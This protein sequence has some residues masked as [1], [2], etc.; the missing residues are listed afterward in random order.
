MALAVGI[1]AWVWIPALEFIVSNKLMNIG[2]FNVA[3]IH[4]IDIL[5]RLF[6]GEIDGMSGGFPNI[7]CGIPALLLLPYFFICKRINTKEKIIYSLL[8][9][10]LVISCVFRPLYI[11]WHGFEVPNGWNYRFAYIISFVICVIAA[12]TVDRF[13]LGPGLKK[14]IPIGAILLLMAVL[15]RDTSRIIVNTIIV[16]VW[17]IVFEAYCVCTVSNRKYVS[18]ILLLLSACECGLC[19]YMGFHGSD[20]LSPDMYRVMYDVWHMGAEE[21]KETVDVDTD[22]FRV[23]YSND[24]SSNAGT[25]FDINCI[26]YFSPAEN[27]NVRRTLSKLGL[28]TTPRAVYGYGLTPVTKML[29]DIR[30]DIYGTIVK[31]DFNESDLHPSI[32]RNDMVLGMGYL[33]EGNEEDYKHID[34]RDAF[35]NMNNLISAMTGE[36]NTAFRKINEQKIAVYE[37]GIKLVNDQDGYEIIRE[38]DEEDS[39]LEFRINIAE[40]ENAYAYV[41]NNASQKSSGRSTFLMEDGDENRIQDIGELSVSYIKPMQIYGKE[42]VL[43]IVPVGDI[44]RQRVENLYFYKYDEGELKKAY[45]AIKDKELNVTEYSDG[46]LKGNIEVDDDRQLLFTTIPYEQ[47]WKLRING[48][49]QDII[50]ILDEAFIAVKLP[51]KGTYDIELSF[52]APGRKIGVVITAIS[53]LAF[54]IFL[55]NRKIIWSVET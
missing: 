43:K 49:Q 10:I 52:V 53:S 46:Y 5:R 48:V 22:L 27:V 33:V 37:H 21:A 41:Y 18:L 51:G 32:I 6:W 16:F 7:Y 26:G 35:T 8:L 17:V 38:T 3:N 9:G 23:N 25:Y 39:S 54:F 42:Y 44:R 4:V 28:Y 50:P 29:L 40:A 45:N 24:Y 13:A 2:E 19:G 31:Y 20:E 34:D 12:M 1:S 36:E 30:Y 15:M 11:L 55:F 47:G 14:Y